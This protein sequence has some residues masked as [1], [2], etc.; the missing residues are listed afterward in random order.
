MHP[1]GWAQQDKQE[2]KYVERVFLSSILNVLSL[3]SG[4]FSRFPSH[5]IF[6]GENSHMCKMSAPLK[7]DS[8]KIFPELSKPFLVVRG[9]FRR[10]YEPGCDSDILE[11]N[12]VLKKSILRG[13]HIT[14]CIFRKSK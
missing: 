9:T 13:D 2:T 1:R 3:T 12:G 5:A 8:C 4:H 7:V 10:R 11:N 14:P 6:A